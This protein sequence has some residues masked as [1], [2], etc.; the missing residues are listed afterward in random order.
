MENLKTIV[1]L[2]CDRFDLEFDDVFDYICME[3]GG[4]GVGW[5][6]GSGGSGGDEEAT[7]KGQKVK[8]RIKALKIKDHA[9][10]LF[11]PITKRLYKEIDMEED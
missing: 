3:L 2:I 9:G 7:D 10:V 11:D 5:G 4:T 8:K 6:G 1:T